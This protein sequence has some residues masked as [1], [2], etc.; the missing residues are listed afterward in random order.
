GFYKKLTPLSGLSEQLF[1]RST[2][3]STYPILCGGPCGLKNTQH[4]RCAHHNIDKKYCQI[5]YN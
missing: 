4:L 3:N 2:H 1:T 5:L